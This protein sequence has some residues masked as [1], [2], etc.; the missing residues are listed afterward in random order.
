M[1]YI[2]YAPICDFQ[3]KNYSI[4]IWGAFLGGEDSRPTD[5]NMGPWATD[6][7][8]HEVSMY[9]NMV[10]P[11]IEDNGYRTTMGELLWWVNSAGRWTKYEEIFQKE[12]GKHA[13]CRI[14]R[15]WSWLI[16]VAG[17]FFESRI[18]TVVHSL[19][20]PVTKNMSSILI[21]VIIIIIVMMITI[22]MVMLH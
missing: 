15:C 1:I 2:V 5:W 11:P 6:P 16:F 8:D 17:C 19:L 22:I 10:W 21:P 20:D 3:Q 9:I 18:M 7:T 4:P 12:R 13:G 14:V